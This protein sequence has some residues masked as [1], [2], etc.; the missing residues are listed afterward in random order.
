MSDGAVKQRIR[1]Y[2]QVAGQASDAVAILAVH[3]VGVFAALVDG[4]LSAVELGERCGVSGWRLGAF[5]D[6]V[7]ASGFLVKRDNR[8][9]LVAGDEMIFDVEHGHGA[10]LGF[11]SVASA[12]GRL[13]RTVEVLR[14]D[15]HMQLAGT[16]GEATA[17]DRGRFLSYLHTRS[18]DGADELAVLLSQEPVRRVVDLG[19]GLGTYAAALLRHNPDATAVLVDRENARDAVEGFLD[20]ERLSERARFIGGDF[21]TDEFGSGHDLALLGN[22]AH[23]LGEDVM[24]ALLLRTHE[25]LVSGGRVMVKDLAVDDDRLGPVGPARF[26]ITMAL[27]TPRGGV[28]PGSEVAAWVAE[29]GF[30]VEAVVDLERAAGSYAVIGRKS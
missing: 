30:T 22:L 19:S 3:E 29:S 28:F 1:A 18:L 6:R 13:A 17:E 7:A 10:A 25:R 15:Q 8:Y 11:S 20:A 26:A 9:G 21:L 27:V 23:N 2:G 14:S 12:F 16:G 4:P 5:L 24:R